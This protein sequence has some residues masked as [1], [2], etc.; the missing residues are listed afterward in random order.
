MKK[1]GSVR[2][3]RWLLLIHAIPP[4]PAYFR[5]KVGRRLAAVG[6]VPLK[7]SVYV[8]PHAER[9][10]EDLQWIAR[11]IKTEGGDATLVEA[12][13]VEGLRDNQVEAIFRKARDEDYAALTAEVRKVHLAA[14]RKKRADHRP[15]VEMARVHKRL[16]EICAIDFFDAKGRA[17]AEAAVRE[18]EALVAHPSERAV[19][20][21]RVKASAY[22]GRVWVTRQNVHVDR[23]ASAWL[24]QRFIDPKARFKF[25]LGKEYRAARNEVVFD[26]F[27]GEF[28]HVGDASTF[29]VLVERFGLTAAGLDRIAEIIHD[30]DVKDGKFGRNETA[31][32][33]AVIAGIA[34][35]EAKDLA[36]IAVGG[37]LL[38]ALLADL[39]GKRAEG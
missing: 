10:L 20:L 8:M 27:E 39:A 36:R 11:Q 35:V 37:A 28:T 19:Q 24:V 4:K 6:A 13:L 29:E 17:T 25:V 12:H 18:L 23:I 1:S 32:V 33:A 7:N 30:I 15:D 2:T 3:H 5:A 21:P 34:R 14:S 31:G 26:M 38:D 22:R 9:T 16:A